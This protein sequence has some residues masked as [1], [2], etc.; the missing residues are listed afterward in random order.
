M[1]VDP[2]LKAETA[3]KNGA[4]SEGPTAHAVKGRCRCRQAP[5][6]AAWHATRVF[7]VLIK[8]RRCA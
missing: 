4:K 8:Q 1:P 7:P 5:K 2:Y 3:R 6:A